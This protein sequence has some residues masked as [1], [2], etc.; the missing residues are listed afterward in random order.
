VRV[1]AKLI[2]VASM[3]LAFGVAADTMRFTAGNDTVRLFDTPCVNL[4]VLANIA[5]RYQAEMRKAEVTV[6]GQNLAACWI[7]DGESARL[8][9][10]DGDQGL[11]R[12]TSF[13]LDE[14]A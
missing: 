9:Y 13:K 2:I 6:G 1:A 4:A 12:L 7:V 5:P 14:G 11:I 10:E 3:L 8:M